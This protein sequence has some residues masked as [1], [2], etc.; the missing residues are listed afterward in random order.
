MS[1]YSEILAA[2]KPRVPATKN[3]SL[4]LRAEEVDQLD[5]ICTKSEI[6]RPDLLRAIVRAFLADSQTDK[7][8]NG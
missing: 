7:P 3:V 8:S 4:T 5:A 6:E 2:A 1:N